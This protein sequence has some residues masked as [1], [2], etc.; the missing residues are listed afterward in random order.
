[1]YTHSTSAT[2]TKYHNNLIHEATTPSSAALS[3]SLYPLRAQTSD[4]AH[5]CVNVANK[6][7]VDTQ[8][9]T[10]GHQYRQHT[11]IDTHTDTNAHKSRYARRRHTRYRRAQTSQI[12]T[13]FFI[14][15]IPISCNLR[16]TINMSTCM[17]SK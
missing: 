12:Y 1:M 8:Y 11:D 3:S 2:T 13:S 7:D 9:Q 5:V 14:K 6:Q 15:N 10:R 16:Q 4:H 17:R